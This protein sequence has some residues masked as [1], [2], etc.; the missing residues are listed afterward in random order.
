M[1]AWFHWIGKSYY[2]IK[3]FQTEAHSVGISRRVSLKALKQMQWGDVVS[4]VQSEY[5]VKAGSIFLEFPVQIISGLSEGAQK[6]MVDKFDARP[7]DFGCSVV[8]RG[9]GEYL[10]G[11]TYQVDAPVS[12][13]ADALE[14]AVRDKLD[15][16]KPMIGCYPDSVIKVKQPHPRLKDVPFRQGFRRYDRAEL[17]KEYMDFQ[18]QIEARIGA[19]QEVKFNDRR[20]ILRGQFYIEGEEE[21]AAETGDVQ[22]VLNYTKKGGR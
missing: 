4:C 8:H 21:A 11:L 18:F 3:A 9:C 13:I 12:N 7:V 17:M 20:L 10:T 15:I 5:R 14:E 1:S 19:G 16:G 6:L 22:A 2:T